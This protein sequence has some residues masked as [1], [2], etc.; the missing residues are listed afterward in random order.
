MVERAR[1]IYSF[2]HL[3][4]QEYFTACKIAYISNPKALEIGLQQ[5]VTHVYE[6]RWREVFLLT[7]T[8]LD[9]ADELLLAMKRAIDSL[10]KDQPKIREI[11]A[12][13]NDKVKSVYSSQNIYKIRYFYLSL[14]LDLHFEIDR[15]FDFSQ[16]IDS[17]IDIDFYID[18]DLALD[19]N[20]QEILRFLDL[21][22]DL[23]YLALRKTISL[24]KQ[25]NKNFSLFLQKLLNLFPDEEEIDYWEQNYCQ[26]WV[27]SLTKSMI[28][29]RNIGHDWCLTNNEENLLKEYIIGNELLIDCLNS[30]CYLSR[31]VREKIENTLFLLPNN[32]SLLFEGEI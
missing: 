13:A 21:D 32:G 27:E 14:D 5:L 7:T 31:D 26:D 10:V 25:V 1:G 24:A 23:I 18:Y 17:C 19:L 29:Y 2:S 22:F 28:K 6:P 15:Y 20:L 11:L 16:N 9:P 3:T 12:W 8:L 4:F 30:E